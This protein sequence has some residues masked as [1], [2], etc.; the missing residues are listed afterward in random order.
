MIPPTK[1]Y[2]SGCSPTSFLSLNM[3]EF[4]F[5]DAKLKS[6]S[7]RCL[8]PLLLFLVLQAILISFFCWNRQNLWVSNFLKFILWVS[9]FFIILWWATAHNA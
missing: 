6:G 5:N 4:Y 9:N 7:P 3:E 2:G 1:A 8:C